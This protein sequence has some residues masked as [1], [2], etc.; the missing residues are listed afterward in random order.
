MN[1]LKYSTL[2]HFNTFVTCAYK[3][4]IKGKWLYLY[5]GLTFRKKIKQNTFKITML[6]TNEQC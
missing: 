6:K 4:E 1:T 2:L 5:H 3:N